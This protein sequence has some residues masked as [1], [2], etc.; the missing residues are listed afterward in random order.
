MLIYI[1]KW[2]NAIAEMNIITALV[3]GHVELLAFP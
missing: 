1:I 2:H 3:Y